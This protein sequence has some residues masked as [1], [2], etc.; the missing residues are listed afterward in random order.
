MTSLGR[1]LGHIV[2][3]GVPNTEGPSTEKP[4]CGKISRLDDRVGT[5]SGLKLTDC[6]ALLNSSNSNSDA[7]EITMDQK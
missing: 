3:V 5:R 7:E 1:N 4:E 6:V 2:V